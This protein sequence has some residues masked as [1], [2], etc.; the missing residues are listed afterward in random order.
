MIRYRDHRGS[1]IDSLIT[2]CELADVAALAAHISKDMPGKAI[3]AAELTFVPYGGDDDRCGWRN[4]HI[5]CAR[6]RVFGFCEGDPAAPIGADARPSTLEVLADV[7]T[8][9]EPGCREPSQ[10]ARTIA[11]MLER[12]GVVLRV[13]GMK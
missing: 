3:V 7:V 5:V 12:R 9:L 6:R 11:D 10:V 2:A 13:A 8:V 1:L 4:V